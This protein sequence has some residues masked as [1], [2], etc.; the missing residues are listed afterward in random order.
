MA[1]FPALTPDER[2]YDLGQVPTAEYRGEG[3]VAVLFTTG[4]IAVGQRLVLPFTRRPRAEIEAI[5]D[6]YRAQQRATFTLPADVWCGHADGAAMA[7]ASLVWR[8]AEVPEVEWGSA[9]NYSITVTLEAVGLSIGPTVAGAILATGD[10]GAVTGAAI[11]ALPSKPTPIPDPT[12]ESP[13]TVSTPAPESL[14]P[15]GVVAVGIGAELRHSSIGLPESGQVAAGAE[16]ELRH[17]SIGIPESGQV[18][19]GEEADLI[20]T[21]P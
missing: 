15:A 6:H 20:Y 12:P 11:T 4:S 9:G 2:G 17:S 8:Y 7:D 13:V 10:V 5:W 14:T 3:G 21:A 18:A 19:V 16:V 1:Q